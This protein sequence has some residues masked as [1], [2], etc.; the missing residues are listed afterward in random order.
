MIDDRSIYDSYPIDPTED[1]YE[2]GTFLAND[3]TGL[4]PGALRDRSELESYEDIYPYLPPGGSE[5]FLP[6]LEYME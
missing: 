4:I 1:D 6:D 2:M 5:D 3:C